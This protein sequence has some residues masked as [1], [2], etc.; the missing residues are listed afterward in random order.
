[1]TKQQAEAL[2]IAEQLSK[3]RH[4]MTGWQAG[5]GKTIPNED[6]ARQAIL[7]LHDIAATK[8]K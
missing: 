5:S 8:K 4:W 7:L 6:A 2:R 3:L 1:M